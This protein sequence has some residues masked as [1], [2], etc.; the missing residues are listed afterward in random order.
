MSEIEGYE[1]IRPEYVY[2]TIPA[3]Y[4]CTYH[5]LLTY[6]A[7]FGKDLINDCSAV[8]KGN[9]KSVITCWNMFQ[10]AVACHSL[11][12]TEEADLFIK[13]IDSQLAII[14]GGNNE[15]FATVG[16]SDDGHLKAIVS[17][18]DDIHFYVDAETGKLYQEYLN[19]KE[20]V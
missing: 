19:K 11:G 8:C 12:R 17:C 20:G 9:N 7:D 14:Y 18:C 4:V 6:M 13:Y 15:T 10:S 3:E 1:E 2:L 16:I 5:K